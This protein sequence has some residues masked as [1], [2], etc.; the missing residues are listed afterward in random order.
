[1]TES[2]SPPLSNG[3]KSEISPRLWVYW[4]EL[5]IHIHQTAQTQGVQGVHLSR[6]V[7][8]LPYAQLMPVARR[9]WARVYP[10]GFVPQFQ[11][12]QNWASQVRGFVLDANDISFEA[13]RDVLTAA[14]LVE[15][16]GLVGSGA[17]LDTEQ[18]DLLAQQLVEAAHQLASPAAAIAPDQ[19]PAWATQM[20]ETVFSTNTTASFTATFQWLRWESALARLALAWASTSAYATDVLFDD[21]LVKSKVDCLMV[22]E[23]FQRDPLV[24]ALAKH[25]G[26][27]ALLLP[28]LDVMASDQ[29]GPGDI[30][31]H[32]ALDAQDEAQRAAACVLRHIE[33][34]RVPVALAATDRALTRRIRAMLATQD[35]AVKDE[36][37]WKLSTTRAASH[38]M[39]SL[40]ACAWNASS[41]SV[42][43]W[44][45]NSTFAT[46]T[47]IQTWEK[48]LR[49]AGITRWQAW[50]QSAL[51]AAESVEATDSQLAAKV[52]AVLIEA[53]RA[54]LQKPRTLAAWLFALR[55]TLQA[56]GQWTR[57]QDD[58]AGEKVLTVL[59]LNEGGEQAYLDL[60]QAQRRLS[61]AEFK[62]W[63]D[64]ALESSSFVPLYPPG[65]Q[66]AQVVIVPMSQLLARPFA[67]AVLPGCDEVRFNPSPDL[68]GLWSAAER[69]GLGLTT[70]DEQ[71]A[72]TRAAWLCALQTPVCDVL[73]RQTE[74]TGEPLL[75]SA[76]V[77]SLALI[78]GLQQPISTAAEPRPVRQLEAAP[79]SKPMPVGD[80]LPIKRLS[81]SAYDKL[82]TCP[83]QF[84]A[85]QQLG[86]Q[87][88]D[89]LEDELGKRDFGL[90][91]HAVL[92]HFHEA[93]KNES[94]DL[95]KSN[96]V[97]ADDFIAKT[98][99]LNIASEAVTQSMNLLVDAFLPWAA[100]WPKVRDGY[101]NWLSTHEAQGWQ[102]DQ[103]EVSKR[104]PLG[105]LTLIGRIDRIDRAA[106]G[107][108]MVLDYK[109]E[110]ASVT[111]SRLKEPLEDTQLAF[112]G[113]LVEADSL[114][115]GYINVGEAGSKTYE[116][117]D[118]VDSRDALIAGILD[119]MQ[120]IGDGAAL[121]A[122]GEGTACDYCAARGLCRKDF[123]SD[124]A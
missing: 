118:V 1:M 16:S 71:D 96:M 75:A 67:A 61:L 28:S 36:N 69:K 92:S 95:N 68:P 54:P 79:T 22:L 40:S 77:Q 108:Q 32:K 33:A 83:Y 117:T 122:L 52:T 23:G 121:P 35:V 24:L 100:T 116:Q 60:P 55:A 64:M 17:N 97:L 42:L 43:D 19:R 102:F 74:S 18:R 31:L 20:Q 72:A 6:C 13:A 38:I 11:T 84:F 12:T 51:V 104:M 26:G 15:Q 119:D 94:N 50:V 110:G 45:K 73:W 56:S 113:A 120:R 44:L 90:W 39:V 65:S 46:A 105:D 98:A 59:H 62:D 49:R 2:K 30:Q 29:T 9:Y 58:L 78:L 87:E 114:R 88:N 124:V 80:Q 107:T 123:W 3:P 10:S 70:R 57:L 86:L 115:A 85:L 89:E 8:L 63:V 5:C 25:W 91:L 27:H 106:D 41:D 103:S 101:L 4:Q 48:E 66:E 37:G 34:G 99:L 7:V 47:Q 82:R 21:R 93:L 111:S 76:L 53:L 109:T 112:Y 14:S 81:S